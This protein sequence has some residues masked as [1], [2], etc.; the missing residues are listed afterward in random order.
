[1]PSRKLK[2]ARTPEIA[3]ARSLIGGLLQKHSE[4]D[5]KVVAA[6]A[7]LATANRRATIEGYVEG[8]VE[9]WPEIS[10]DQRRRIA[11]LIGGSG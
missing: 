2:N 4:D 7:A 11:E 9:H 6:R 3:H 10:D 5:P 1:M 8:V